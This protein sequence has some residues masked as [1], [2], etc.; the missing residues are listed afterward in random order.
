MENNIKFH[1]FWFMISTEKQWYDVM[2]E[3]RAWF[4]KDWRSMSKVRRKLT[5]GNQ[6]RWRTAAIPVWFEVPDERFASWCAVKF[7]LQVMSDAK[8]Q[9]AK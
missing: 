9:A 1:R 2:R 4:G 7:S 3:A 8:Y 5:R 6:L